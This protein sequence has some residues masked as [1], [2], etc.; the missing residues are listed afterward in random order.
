MLDL[1]FCDFVES[2]LTNAFGSSTD[3]RLKG[4]SCDGVLLPYGDNV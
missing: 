4:S 3:D 2:E 1:D